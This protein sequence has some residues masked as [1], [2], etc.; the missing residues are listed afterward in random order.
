MMVRRPVVRKRL[1]RAGQGMPGSRRLKARSEGK[2]MDFKDFFQDVSGKA[3]HSSCTGAE[4][5]GL[6]NKE[7]TWRQ[8][9]G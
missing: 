4:M 3:A 6:S 1:A 5:A 7:T 2:S 8:D 9:S